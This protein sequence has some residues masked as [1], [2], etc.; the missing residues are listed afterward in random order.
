MTG[1]NLNFT[2]FLSPLKD[3]ITEMIND[4]RYVITTLTTN[5]NEFP[6]RKTIE[7]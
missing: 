6:V 1:S 3:A 4:E 2:D 7:K 5:R